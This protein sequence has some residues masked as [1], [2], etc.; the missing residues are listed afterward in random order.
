[1]DYCSRTESGQTRSIRRSSL[2]QNHGL[3]RPSCSSCSN[4][5]R[6]AV[7]VSGS[8][9]FAFLPSPPSLHLGQEPRLFHGW[10]VVICYRRPGSPRALGVIWT[11]D[12]QENH[13]RRK[14]CLNMAVIAAIISHCLF[15]S[16]SPASNFLLHPPHLSESPSPRQFLL[17]D[18]AMPGSWCGLGGLTVA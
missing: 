10:E 7:G 15:I 4:T 17:W 3:R 18:P 5:L 11:G 13:I 14:A 16:R 8:P 2:G 1:M 9:S 6:L 12:Q